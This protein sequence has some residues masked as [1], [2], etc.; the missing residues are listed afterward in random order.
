MEAGAGRRSYALEGFSQMLASAGGTLQLADLGGINQAN[1]DFVT[2]FGHRLYGED[3]LRSYDAFFSPQERETGAP[4]AARVE[5]FLN[6]TLHFPGHRIHG[7]LVW[8]TL[9]FLPAAMSA[10][11]LERL[12]ETLA[13]GGLLMALFHPE[14]AGPTASPQQCRILDS[15]HMTV[16][17]RPVRRR[18]EQFSPRSIERFFG[19]FETVK[20][21][22]T[23]DNLQEVLTRR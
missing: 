22:L 13:P 2:S 20:F 10:A 16:T 14:N 5:A 18:L 4:A 9:Q 23:R 1:L 11:V 15:G 7:A 19:R 6:D 3:L 21:F 17:P 8:D 12:R